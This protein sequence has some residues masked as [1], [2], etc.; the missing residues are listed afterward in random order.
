MSAG[1]IFQPGIGPYETQEEPIKRHAYYQWVPFVLFGQALCF[2]IPHFLWKS[3]EG[4]VILQQNIQRNNVVQIKR[5]LNQNFT[6][7]KLGPN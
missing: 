3:W 1:A 7:I 4:K 5:E 6:I 2:Y